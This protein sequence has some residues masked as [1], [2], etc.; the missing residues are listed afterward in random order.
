MK[1]AKAMRVLTL[2]GTV[3][4]FLPIGFMLLTS[5]VGSITRKQFLMDYMIPSELF[6]I[7][8]AGAVMLT[9]ASFRTGC[10]KK[11]SVFL[12]VIMCA[13]LFA[14]QAV[15]VLTGLASGRTAAE[16]LPLY[17]VLTLMAL[18]NIAAAADII[19]GICMYKSERSKN[20]SEE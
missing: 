20:R 1:S 5:A 4:L 18:Y 15:A 6:P 10:R 16:G 14:S 3:L 17:T 13:A 9:V 2:A 12:L 7:I 19:N 11:Q 8:F